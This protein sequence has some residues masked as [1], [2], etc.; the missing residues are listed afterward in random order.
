MP[1][2][3]PSRVFRRPVRR[4]CQLPP[5]LRA[6]SNPPV[7]LAPKRPR[8]DTVPPAIERFRQPRLAHASGSPSQASRSAGRLRRTVAIAS[9]LARCVELSRRNKACSSAKPRRLIGSRPTVAEIP[10]SV[11][12]A[13]YIACGVGNSSFRSSAASSRCNVARCPLASSES[14]SYSTGEMVTVWCGGCT[15]ISCTSSAG[16]AVSVRPATGYSDDAFD[17]QRLLCAGFS[18]STLVRFWNA[19]AVVFVRGQRGLQVAKKST[20]MISAP[21]CATIVAKVAEDRSAVLRRIPESRSRHL[22]PAQVRGATGCGKILD[23]RRMPSSP[24]FRRNDSA[25]ESRRSDLARHLPRVSRKRT[26]LENSE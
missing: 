6:R 3:L 12:A 10:A 20:V 5:R 23:D 13:R 7:R 18:E 9:L 14:I 21:S 26:Q 24:R 25:R 4:P 2:A 16:D 22:A 15:G 1:T 8:P 19:E 17:R 11:C